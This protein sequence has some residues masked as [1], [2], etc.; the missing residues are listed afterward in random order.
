MKNGYMIWCQV[1]LV[2]VLVNCLFVCH[3]TSSTK[4]SR[5]KASREFIQTS[6]HSCPYFTLKFTKSDVIFTGPFK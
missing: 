6:V 3:I 1:I 2:L 4:F 5:A